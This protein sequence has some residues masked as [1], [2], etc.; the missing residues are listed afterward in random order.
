VQAVVLPISEK[1][2]AYAREVEAELR[3]AKIRVR[4][5]DRNEKLNARVRDAQLQKVPFMLVVG[6]R[7]AE[8]RTVALRRRDSGDAGARPLN[9]F[10]R[11]ARELI[12]TRAIKW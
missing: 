10:V 11:W 5:D 1:H 12:D 8:A 3:A 4:L 2:Q 9:E 6:D 7:E